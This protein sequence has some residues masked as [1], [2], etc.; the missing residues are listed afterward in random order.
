MGISAKKLM[1]SLQFSV[2][3]NSKIH[4]DIHSPAPKQRG[5]AKIHW[6]HPM[7]SKSTPTANHSMQ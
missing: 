5:Q 4:K 2:K 7:K 3:N 1:T 6:K